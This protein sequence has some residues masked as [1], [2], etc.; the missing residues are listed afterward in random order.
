MFGRPWPAIERAASIPSQRTTGTDRREVDTLGWVARRTGCSKLLPPRTWIQRRIR[1]DV[2]RGQRLRRR[3]HVR[4]RRRGRDHRRRSSQRRPPRDPVAG[5]LRREGRGAADPRAARR[6]GRHGDVLHPRTG[7]RAPSGAR[8]SDRLRGTRGGAP[9]IH[10]HIAHQPEPRRRG[11]GARERVGGAPIVRDRRDGLPLAGMG[12][13]RE[14][15]G[16]PRAAPVR[17]QL[18]LHGRPAAVSAAHQRT[19]RAADPVDPRRRGSF[20]VRRRQLEQEDLDRR[21]GTVDLGGR[22]AWLPS[23][24]RCIRP[25]DAP[26]DHR[27]AVPAGV[28]RGIHRSRAGDAGRVGRDVSRDRGEGSM[29]FPHVRLEGDA[30]ERGRSYGEQAAERVR[31]SIAAYREVF[32]AYAGWNWET[33]TDHARAYIDPITRFD[34]AYL[35]EIAGIAEGADV[36]E[37]DVLAI[38]VRT[39]VMF[40]AKARD[41]KR[42]V[43][44]CSAFAVTSTRSAEGH[45]LIGQNWDWLLHSAQ[46]VV[47]VEARQPDRPDYVTVVEAG[48]LAKTGMNSSG[49][50][51]VTNA[52]V[53]GD[54]RGTPG[55]PY[56]VALRAILDADTISDAYAV[57]QGAAR[58]SSANYLIAHRDGQAVNIEGAPGEFDALF[59]TF[60][61]EGLLLH[62]NHFASGGHRGRDVGLGD[63]GQSVPARAA[64]R[65]SG[66][67]AVAVVE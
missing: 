3:V 44:E 15:R 47:V 43:G 59:L 37:A 48:L 19:H 31:R 41:A 10:P 18:E 27:P 21:R 62:T 13:Q 6:Q 51:L 49:I 26:A 23:L 30:R 25:H 38:N 53:S 46:T 14:H 7:G 4:L 22:A 42:R 2:A 61:D 29:T 24:R 11:R 8:P 1:C 17:L 55:V 66:R 60:P 64:S 9:R 20:L 36:D 57:L 63:A 35:D 12:L 54:D 45:T 5:H 16:A 56:H 40:A 50:G 33:V 34:P 67:G 39:E 32:R 58:S 65:A 28:A 52:L